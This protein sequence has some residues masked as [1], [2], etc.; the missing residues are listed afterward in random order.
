MPQPR[1]R[2]LYNSIKKKI[3]KKHPKHSAYRSG[4]LVQAYKKEFKKKYGNKDPYNGKK[5]SKKGLKR[6]FNEEW[7]NQR[8]EIGYKYKGDVYRPSKRITKKTPKTF[9]ELNKKQI[10]KARTKKRKYGRV[11]RF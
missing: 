1:N 6:W 7:L 10:H 3:Y 5:T 8:G 9:K 11:D 4:L 2:K